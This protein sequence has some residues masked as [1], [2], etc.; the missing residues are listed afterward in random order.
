MRNLFLALFSLFV[1]CL[2][3]Q[4]GE[5][6]TPPNTEIADSAWAKTGNSGTVQ[7]TNFIGTT[8]N[9][10]LTIRTNNTARVTIANDGSMGVGTTNPNSTIQVVGSVSET[11]TII[12]ATTALTASQ[13]KILL[14]NGATNITITLPNA[15]TCIGRK[16]E[17][18]R[19]AGST[20][21]VTIV[22][23]GSQIQALAGTVGVTTTLGAHNGTGAGL[24]HSFTAVNVG[25]VGVWVRL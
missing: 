7:S 6:Y 23:T 14:T 3:A 4:T 11:I 13:N 12:N 16:Y 2:N 1:V 8:D 21:T 19:Y 25:G 20:G 10:G 5:S 18:S 22:G 17:S 24:R 15:L 9:V